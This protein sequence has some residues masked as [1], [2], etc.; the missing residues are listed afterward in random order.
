MSGATEVEVK[1][2]LVVLFLNSKAYTSYPLHARL[3]D[4]SP[5]ILPVQIRKE[6]L[7]NRA[8]LCMH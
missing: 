6:D 1:H 2:C 7:L 3:A 8:I 4:G 5:F